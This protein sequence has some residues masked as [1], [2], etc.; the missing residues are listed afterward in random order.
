MEELLEQLQWLK[1]RIRLRPG[2]T[3]PSDLLLQAEVF[4]TSSD[5]SSAIQVLQTLLG[6]FSSRSEEFKAIRA[7]LL[8]LGGTYQAQL[9]PVGLQKAEERHDFRDFC[10]WNASEKGELLNKCVFSSV[11]TSCRYTDMQEWEELGQV[12]D[13][14]N[15]MTRG[16]DLMVEKASSVSHINLANYGAKSCSQMPCSEEPAFFYTS[17]NIMIENLSFPT[18]FD[19]NLSYFPHKAKG[20][21]TKRKID[22]ENSN[23]PA[24]DEAEREDMPILPGK[25][26]ELSDNAPIPLPQ[27]VLMTGNKRIFKQ[28]R[29]YFLEYQYAKQFSRSFEP[30]RAQICDFH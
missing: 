7:L 17:L 26:L 19:E 28:M 29:R 23:F 3:L 1:A 6:M 27:Q 9:E 20:I 24:L 30:Q 14:T 15:L 16:N 10:A 21:Q 8:R 2:T 18:V 4:L 11:E 5:P 25:S 22:W 13:Q 12:K